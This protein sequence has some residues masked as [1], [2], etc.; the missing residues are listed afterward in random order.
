MTQ[1]LRRGRPHTLSP[2]AIARAREMRQRGETSEVIAERLGVSTR[3]IRR[4]LKSEPPRLTIHRPGHGM[5]GAIAARI[6]E[7]HIW[8]A[9]WMANARRMEA[10]LDALIA[11]TERGMVQR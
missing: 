8:H 3:T 10:E 9:G 7:F 2:T 6:E 11:D 5:K 1:E 4:V